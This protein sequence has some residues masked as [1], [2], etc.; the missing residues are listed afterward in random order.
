MSPISKLDSSLGLDD[1]EAQGISAPGHSPRFDHQ[2]GGIGSVRCPTLG[3]RNMG[4]ASTKALGGDP[5]EMAG[6]EFK[7]LLPGAM[8]SEALGV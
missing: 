1:R 6:P 3:K 4:A 5:T 7:M 8:V 2:P